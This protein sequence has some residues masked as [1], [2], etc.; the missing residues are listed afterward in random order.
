MSIKSIFKTKDFVIFDELFGLAKDLEGKTIILPEALEQRGIADVIEAFVVN[1]YKENSLFTVNDKSTKKGVEDFSI[2]FGNKT[3]LIDVKS[4][5]IKS[6]FSMPNLTA[7]DRLIKL[8]DNDSVV[9][10]YLFIHYIKETK[11][12]IR[13]TKVDDCLPIQL[14][15]NHLSI[16]NLGNGQLQ[17]KDMHLFNKTDMYSEAEWYDIFLNE[18]ISFK[19]KQINKMTT[20]LSKWQG[21]KEKGI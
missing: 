8:K 13:I 9:F 19:T 6:D 10:H 2:I 3:H 18:I 17:I 20:S 14:D 4:F 7:I 15:W 5:N 21:F 1:L 11:T 16:A 12:S